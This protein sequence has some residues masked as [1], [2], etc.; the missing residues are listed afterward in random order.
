MTESPVLNDCS[1]LVKELTFYVDITS[2]KVM[3][4]DL[5]TFS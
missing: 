3:I 4:T 5:K 2:K 1:I